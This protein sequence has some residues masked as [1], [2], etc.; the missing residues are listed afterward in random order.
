MRRL[1][2]ILMMVMVAGAVVAGPAAKNANIVLTSGT[3]GTNTITGAEGYL[4]E[5]QVYV[6]DGVSTGNM[7]VSIQPTGAT[8]AA[9]NIATNSVVDSKSW[10]PSRDFTDITG[11]A[12]TGDEPRRR[13]LVGDTI[14]F[15]VS[16][17]PTN[18]TWTCRVKY[19]DG[20]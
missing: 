18:K 3:A 8:V 13:L 14:S 17:S 20:N 4:D 7:V 10:Y 9:Y 11:A 16:G 5:I 2:D 15:V 1:I 19:D 6:T 12:V